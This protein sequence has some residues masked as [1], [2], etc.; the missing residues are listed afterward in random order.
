M[1]NQHGGVKKRFEDDL[2]KSDYELFIEM[3]NSDGA[4]FQILT[5]K[6]KNGIIFV[7]NVLEDASRYVTLDPETGRFSKL[8]TSFVV[9]LVITYWANDKA[10]GGK[11][12]MK[13]ES[14]LGEARV[15]QHIFTDSIVGGRQPLCPGISGFC[16]FNN[17][18]AK[19][20]LNKLLS[21]WSVDDGANEMIQRLLGIVETPGVG[22]GCCFR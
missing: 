14:F 8:V 13:P 10:F 16:L 17:K 19:K 2:S 4:T 12:T 3:M 6:C 7:L 18:N 1:K 11:Y 15:Q 20:F 21:F 9:K 22:I 5:D